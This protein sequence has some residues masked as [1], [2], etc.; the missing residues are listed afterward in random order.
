MLIF[1]QNL[2]TKT[3]HEH[4]RKREGSEP[5]TAEIS[6]FIYGFE[7][8][9]LYYITLALLEVPMWTRLA[10]HLPISRVLGLKAGT[11]VPSQQ[12]FKKNIMNKF[13]E[14]NLKM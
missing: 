4:I 7:T 8:G 11:S 2:R 9:S 1:Q 3:R 6:F 12:I 5:K 13:M 10:I 14:T